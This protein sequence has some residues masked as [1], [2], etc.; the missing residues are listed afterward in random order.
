MAGVVV[1]TA[2][3]HRRFAWSHGLIRASGCS[4]PREREKEIVAN[5]LSSRSEKQVA[6]ALG[7]T[8]RTTHLGSTR[9]LGVG[10]RA[11]LIARFLH[12]ASPLDAKAPR[13]G[14]FP[15]TSAG[16]RPTLQAPRRDAA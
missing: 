6:A 12:A 5:L 10:S 8:E 15:S 1:Q 13:P 14:L 11:E 7:L 3:L 16:P 4:T 2:W 9:K